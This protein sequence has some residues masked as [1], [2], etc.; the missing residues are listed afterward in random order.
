[1]SLI[2]FVLVLGR[3]EEVEVLL[4]LFVI[5]MGHQPIEKLVGLQDLVEVLAKLAEIQF[6]RFISTF[7]EVE[8]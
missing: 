5:R 7:G 3:L 4:G 2:V 6:K 8:I 1:M